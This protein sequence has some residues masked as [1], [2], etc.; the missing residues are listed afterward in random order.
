LRDL[1]LNVTRW[2]LR[3]QTYYLLLTDDY[4]PFALEA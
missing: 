4:P 2:Y 3:V 1:V